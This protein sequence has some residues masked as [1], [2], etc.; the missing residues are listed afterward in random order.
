[1]S[2]RGIICI[3][4]N[5]PEECSLIILKFIVIVIVSEPDVAKNLD[6]TAGLN[7]L[8]VKWDGPVS[9][10]LAERYT[11]E[12]TEK[13]GSKKEIITKTATFDNLTSGKQ[14]TVVVVA[15]SGDLSS[16]GQKSDNLM[17]HFYTSKSETMIKFFPIYTM[18]PVC[19]CHGIV[20]FH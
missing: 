4:M 16:G 3:V 8:T 6:A 18:V 11:V 20:K 15:L 17:G 12:L 10:G 1:M 14:Y 5:Y 19:P 7:S 2:N 9:P 13:S